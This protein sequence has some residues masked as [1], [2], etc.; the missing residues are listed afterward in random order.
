MVKRASVEIYRDRSR[1]WRWRFRAPNGPI[2]AD[3]AESYTRRAS[4]L[5][6]FGRFRRYCRGHVKDRTKPWR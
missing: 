3:S 2:I 5:L 4:A 1:G 6:A